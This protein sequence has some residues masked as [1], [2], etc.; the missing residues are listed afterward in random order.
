M[1]EFSIEQKQAL[2]D[3]IVAM[4]EASGLSGND[5]AKK[6][7]GFTSGSK[8][9]HI[10]N[11]WDK[12][13]LVGNDT[14]EVV[15]KVLN[16]KQRY[17]GVPTAN[18]RKVFEACELAYNLKK[19]VPVIGNGGYGKTFALTNY[20]E[21]VEAQKRFKV[22]YY[23]AQKGTPKQFIAGLME[24][25]GCYRAG[26]MAA[27]IDEMRQFAMRQ[28]MVVLIDEVSKLE[29]HHVTVVKDVMTALNGV[30]GI[31]L[32]G[33]PYF[34]KNLTRGAHRD[35]HLFSETKDRLFY[36][37]F[38]LEPPTEVEA[39][40][41]FQANG[42]SDKQTLDILLNRIGDRAK[43]EAL[44]CRSWLAKPTFRGIADCID[45]IKATQMESAIDYST[46]ELH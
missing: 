9:S 11:N 5:F 37:T 17:Q 8:F 31:V 18:L 44:R 7:L 29:G 25:F 23:E 27:Q 28:D 26:T 24:A 20:K 30:C 4:Q 16:Q 14:W 38:S 2:R 32:A 35:R 19:F 3:A 36:I 22:V 13:G 43:K 40:Q 15:E 12:P 41:I 39:E 33:T 10:R 42:I 45:T 34:M 1:K 46:L 6:R 21:M